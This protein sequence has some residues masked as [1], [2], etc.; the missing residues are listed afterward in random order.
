[1]KKTLIAL[2]SLAGVATAQEYTGQFTWTNT[3]GYSFV[4]NNSELTMTDITSSVTQKDIQDITLGSDP[5]AFIVNESSA[6]TP[7]VNIGTNAGTWTLTFTLSN[8]TE[9]TFSVEAMKLDV[10]LFNNGGA[11]QQDD[12]KDRAVAFTLSV[13]D[14]ETSTQIGSVTMPG[15]KAGQYYNVTMDLTEV[16]TL[17]ARDSVVFALKAADGNNETVNGTFV[18]LSAVGFATSHIPDTP[19]V[20]EPATATLSLLALAGLA[21]RRRRK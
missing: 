6:Y 16:Y 17:E 1:M 5:D 11:K 20:P 19:A 8:T 13:L 4:F 18:G 9:S 15:Y 3:D 2:V 10:F 14:G 21:A 7:G 12:G